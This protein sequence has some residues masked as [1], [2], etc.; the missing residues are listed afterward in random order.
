M[1]NNS[2][3]YVSLTRL[4]DFLDNIKEKYSQIGHKHTISDLTDYK[5]D[6]ELSSTSTNPVQNKVLDAEFEAIST[7]MNALDSAIDGKADS[8]HLHDNR[9]YTKTEIDNMELITV[10]NIDNI[11]G[12]TLS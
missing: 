4:S 1:A 3:K 2:R 12:G 5:I 8:S 10:E 7:A 11:C 6:T 9:Y